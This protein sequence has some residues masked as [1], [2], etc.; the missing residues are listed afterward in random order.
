M[1]LQ[2]SVVEE[3]HK[4]PLDITC[5][6]Q[7]KESYFIHCARCIHSKGGYLCVKKP[8]PLPKWLSRSK[9]QNTDNYEVKIVPSINMHNDNSPPPSLSITKFLPL[10]LPTSI[11]VYG[12]L[13]SLIFRNHFV[14]KCHSWRPPKRHDDA[15]HGKKIGNEIVEEID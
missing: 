2:K 5:W 14:E 6:L 15:M 10:Q 7:R 13:H 4:V 12:R 1:A 9:S 3:D 8:V 11:L